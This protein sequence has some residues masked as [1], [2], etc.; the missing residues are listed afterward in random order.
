LK[1]IQHVSFSKSGGA[2]KVAER[3]QLFQ[4]NLPDYE[5][6]FLF[7]FQGSIRSNKFADLT[8]TSR[9]VIDNKIIKKYDGK[10]LLSLLRN[11]EN[12]K[13]FDLIKMHPGINHLHW[14][15]GIINFDSLSKLIK[16]NK[17]LIWTVHDMEP[18]TGGCHH[19]LDCNQLGKECIK[20]PIVYPPF[21]RYVRNQFQTKQ[22]FYMNDNSIFYAF[23]S[24]WMQKQFN[25]AFP[26]VEIRSTII[27]NPI[28][29]IFFESNKS[30]EAFSTS[31]PNELVVGFVSISLND[32]LKRFNL[33]LR[34]LNKASEHIKRP[35]TLVAIG[36]PIK[37]NTVMSNVRIIQPGLISDEKTLLRFYTSMDLLISTS[38][39]ESFGLSIAEAG[40]SGIPSLV[41]EG[42]GSS[43]IIKDGLNGLV[44]KNESEFISKLIE[45]ST[46]S[47]LRERLKK[48]IKTHAKENWHIEKVASKYDEIYSELA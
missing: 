11:R 38:L 39:S 9:A 4:M 14:M 25:L 16:L 24:G 5:S 2:G 45:F 15:N 34:I 22:A 43:E 10:V 44:A 18:F 29:S 12:N 41:Q 17:K 35:I 26:D 48:N 27:A 21:R 30:I 32:P 1:K 47:V 3:L 23:P 42:S 20:C 6:T 13:F 7:D 33:V 19:S 8:L 31:S 40:A 36:M 46:N 28:S 37:I